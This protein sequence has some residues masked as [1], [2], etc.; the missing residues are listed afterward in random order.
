MWPWFLQQNVAVVYSL[1]KTT[2]HLP[3]KPDLDESK[4]YLY[5]IKESLILFDYHKV[6]SPSVCEDF[7]FLPKTIFAS[8]AQKMKFFTDLVTFTE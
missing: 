4:F 2:L 1:S 6:Y 3:S 8:T 5:L 7:I